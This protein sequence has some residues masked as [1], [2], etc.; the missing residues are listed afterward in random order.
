MGKGEGLTLLSKE[1][2][3]KEGIE[4]K[5]SQGDIIEMLVSERVDEIK[6]MVQTLD[7]TYND[8]KE[9]LDAEYKA[10][11]KH[12]ASLVKVPKGTKLD[13]NKCS[14]NMQQLGQRNEFM[15][16]RPF[17]G[18]YYNPRSNTL[19]YQKESRRYVDDVHC[20]GSVPVI[21]VIDGV[22]LTGWIEFEFDF[23]HDPKLVTLAEK[24]EKQV[25]AF[26]QSMPP[27]GINENALTKKIKTE[28]TK[29][30]VKTMSPEF[31]KSLKKGFGFNM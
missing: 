13:I 5:V 14:A 18:N 27:E 9:G 25:D 30:F 20:K 15:L 23:K 10:A 1:A 8:L 6:S 31:Q 29:Q 22:R 17:N 24:L 19:Q 3:Q 7:N 16:C 4:V 11:I 28:F 26:I 12:H 2:V 21:K